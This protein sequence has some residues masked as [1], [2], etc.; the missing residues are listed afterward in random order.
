MEFWNSELTEQSW[1][2]LQELKKR[3]DF[4][5]IGGWAIYLWTRQQKSKDIDI[6]IDIKEL[7]KFRQEGLSKNDN[8]KRYEIKKGNIDVDIY[9]SYFSKLAIPAEEISKYSTKIEGFDVVVPEALL[10]LKQQ[11]ERERR[12]TV[13]GEKDKIDVISLLFFTEIDFKKYFLLLKK[14]SIENYSQELVSLV[15]NFND[16]NSLKMTPR[17]LKIKK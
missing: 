10:V 8:L 17:E 16:Y 2:M 13:K 14:Y 3:Y 15:Q 1:Q 5:V 6:V 12:N 9:V 11:A 7:E 4:V